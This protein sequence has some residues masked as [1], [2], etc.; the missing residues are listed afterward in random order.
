MTHDEGR[1]LART[2][3]DYL[4]HLGP[5][6]TR[7][8][9]DTNYS[10]YFSNHTMAT[11]ADLLQTGINDIVE[12]DTESQMPHLT[13]TN[14]AIGQIVQNI[15]ERADGKVSVTD[16]GSG[17]GA[18]LAAIVAG[19][20]EAGRQGHGGQTSILGLESNPDFYASLEQF[21]HKAAR[22]L[23]DA[24]TGLNSETI[25][26][27]MDQPDLFEQTIT[28]NGLAIVRGDIMRSVEHLAIPADQ[29]D[30]SIV[31]ANYVWH[32]LTTES[33]RDVVKSLDAD[34][35]LIADLAENAS[36]VNRRYFNFGN[37]G[38]LNCGNL[39]IEQLFE[40]EKYTVTTLSR[41]NALQLGVHPK[42]AKAIEKEAS[43][44]GRLWIAYRGEKARKL[45]DSYT[46]EL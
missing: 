44:D 25:D 11:A 1:R 26:R 3:D 28:F 6:G 12:T 45:V 36:E 22:R 20:E 33:K 17:T 35:F 18:T 7:L 42:L 39:G 31:T 13:R 10:L 24:H 46:G 5:D 21:M 38:P 19:V 15:I 4:T 41:E 40:D 29:K 32:R 16:M 30:I 37:N 27:L 8:L 43:N 9:A 34:I 14:L 23:F 2:A